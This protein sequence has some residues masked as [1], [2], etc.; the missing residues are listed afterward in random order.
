LSI[1]QSGARQ[2]NETSGVGP[3]LEHVDGEEIM[4]HKISPFLWFDSNAEEAANF[5]V[6]VFKNS[7]IL[8]VSRSGEGG[9]GP[10][11]QAFVVNFNLDGQE[12]KA[13]N[14]GPMFK[15]TEAVSFMIDCADQAEV[16]YYWDKLTEGGEES[17]CGWLK[18]RFGLSWQ[19]TPTNLGD[20]IGGPDPVKA[21]RAMQAML[22]MTKLDI[23]TLQAAYDQD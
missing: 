2:G 6:S 14:G 10:A 12:F 5:Y 22:K 21:N 16:D 15:F 1:S 8:E 7:E 23:A 17:Q 4:A 9:P 3:G 18:D 11:G 19:V 20:L 13:L